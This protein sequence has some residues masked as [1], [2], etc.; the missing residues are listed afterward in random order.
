MSAAMKNSSG[1]IST[2]R[3]SLATMSFAAPPVVKTR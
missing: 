2:A 1:A 3:E